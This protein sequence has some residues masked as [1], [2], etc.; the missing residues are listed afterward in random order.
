MN[1][2]THGRRDR[3]A[4]AW[5]LTH[6]CRGADLLLYR[7]CNARSSVRVTRKV[8]MGSQN[9]ACETRTSSGAGMPQKP[10]GRASSCLCGCFAWRRGRPAG[11][12]AICS[13]LCHFQPAILELKHSMW[14]RCGPGLSRGLSVWQCCSSGRLA[15]LLGSC[16]FKLALSCIPP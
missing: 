3:T 4:A 7:M 2:L 9:R 10:A 8:R 14:V 12:I 1:L 11:T 13:G 15:A 5:S 6:Q 16:H